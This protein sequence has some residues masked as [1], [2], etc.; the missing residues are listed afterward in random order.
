LGL[1]L[2][3]PIRALREGLD[4]FRRGDMGVRFASRMG[5][6]RDE[7]ADLAHDFDGMAEKVEQLCCRAG[8]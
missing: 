2:S 8:N 3:L 5:R 1:Y 6:R 4:R 7:I